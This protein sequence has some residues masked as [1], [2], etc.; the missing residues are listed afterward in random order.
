MAI[1]FPDSPSVND[2]H[3]VGSRKWQWTG[4]TW[5]SI[6]SG[7]IDPAVGGDLTGTA[8][9]AQ[10]AADAVGSAEIADNTVGV[11]ELNITDG[12]VGQALMTDGSGTMTFGDVD[13]LPSQ[14]G[15]AGEF[16]KT[17]GTTATWEAVDALPSQT[18]QAGEYLQTDGTTA[19]WELVTG[20]AEYDS[21]TASTGYFDL[22]AG[23]TAQRPST[24]LMGNVRYNTDLEAME[25]YSGAAWVKFA[26]ANPTISG[27]SPVSFDG[28][29]G[30]SITVSG[31]NFQA[32]FTLKLIGNDATQYNPGSTTFINDTE[33]SFTTPVLLV[34][35]EPYD[36]K[37]TLPSGGTT[38]LVDALD[39]GG[40]PSWTSYTGDPHSLGT[41][42][43]EATG[44]HFTLAA[45]DPESQAITYA[46][47]GAIWSGQNLT[48]N[49]DGTITGDPTD[50]GSATTFNETVRATDAVGNITDKNF[51]IGISPPNGVSAGDGSDGVLTVTGLT[52][53]NSYYSI[54]NTTLGSGSTAFVLDTVT[55]LAAGDKVLV[56]QMQHY[57]DSALAGKMI[58]TTIDSINQGTATATTTDNITWGMMSADY[59]NDSAHTAQLVKIPQYTSVTINN[60]G[61]MAPGRWDG[62]KGG[63]LVVECQNNFTVNTGGYLV[64]DGM[65][66][67]GGHGGT[68]SS[69]GKQGFRGEDRTGCGVG[70]SGGSGSTAPNGQPNLHGVSGSRGGGSGYGAG[71]SGGGGPAGGGAFGGGQDTDITGNKFLPGGGGGGGGGGGPGNHSS[72]GRGG[73]GGGGGGGVIMIRCQNFVN[74]GNVSSK[75]GY[76]GGGDGARDSGGGSFAQAG[77][78]S[79]IP[80][81]I[82]SLDLGNGH[83]S[84]NTYET[85]G[86]E[87]I[88]THGGN[89]TGAGGPYAMGTS[90]GGGSDHGGWGGATGVTGGGNGGQGDIG[91]DG[92]GGG[93]AG[94]SGGG[95]GSG[96]HDIAGG[97]GGGMGGSGGI[98]WIETTTA[99]LGVSLAT[100]RGI[101]GGGGAATS[102][103]AS[104]GDSGG[105]AQYNPDSATG[106]SWG[107]SGIAQGC[108]SYYGSGGGAAGYVGGLGKIHIATA[109]G[110]YA[111]SIDV[112]DNGQVQTGADVTTATLT[113]NS[114][115]GTNGY[116]VI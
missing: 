71:G 12:T 3:T 18:G 85:A 97:G 38:T 6:M 54:Q 92:G 7:A 24:P 37:L 30:V 25:Q 64:G 108:G 86:G 70:I 110:S 33:I 22:P 11:S 1:N 63:I 77:E 106:Y 32:G 99:N 116:A 114:P 29:A 89:G 43:N 27:I 65:G 56:W 72:N 52:Q 19:T 5:E 44:T 73:A 101:G 58:Y 105:A 57:G 75:P 60:G 67:R 80:V 91:G 41:I 47:T 79:A 66:F 76:G 88:A 100:P 42:A 51:S 69:G 93:G 8:S 45:T 34:A 17:D 107:A 10:I 94:G 112:T 40:S 15:Q 59:D 84:F 115:F 102:G 50:Q 62:Q 96:G 104:C 49:S 53:P 48:V 98:I 68:A 81:L 103:A 13:A 26:G 2:I 4:N 31:T 39:A 46:A 55:G 61:V 74:G 21:A 78:G 20:G 28:S 83:G 87:A 35:N 90:P 113:G 16:L 14:S 109:T 9:T 36:V 23:T 82:N 111:G 95:G